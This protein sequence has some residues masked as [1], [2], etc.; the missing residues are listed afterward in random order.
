MISAAGQASLRDRFKPKMNEE[1]SGL[2]ASAYIDFV[3][4]AKTRKDSR[5]FLNYAL[6]KGLP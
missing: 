5:L 3:I 4:A 1:K 2:V 6:P